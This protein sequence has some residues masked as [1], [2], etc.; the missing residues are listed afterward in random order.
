MVV[1][2][3]GGVGSGRLQPSPPDQHQIGFRR[4]RLRG[5]LFV[6]LSQFHECPLL[7]LSGHR[8]VRCTCLLL[9]QSGHV[10]GQTFS[11]WILKTR[12]VDIV[13]HEDGD[14]EIDYES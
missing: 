3:L 11:R 1:F 6:S 2:S 12:L 4:D 9:S 14:D 13:E 5:G 8:L 7:A 10:I